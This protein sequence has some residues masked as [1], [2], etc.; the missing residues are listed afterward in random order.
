MLTGYY[1]TDRFSCELSRALEVLCHS[2]SELVMERL[3]DQLE[4]NLLLQD[5]G[6]L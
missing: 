2:Y 5:G 6:V 3:K 4:I 1:G